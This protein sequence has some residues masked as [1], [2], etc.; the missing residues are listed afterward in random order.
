MTFE[1][2]TKRDLECASDNLNIE[3]SEDDLEYYDEVVADLLQEL[4]RIHQ[5]R[6]PWAAP[7]RGCDDTRSYRGFERTRS[8]PAD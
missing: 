3:L 4:G 1:P 7:K 5:L 8:A 6:E 2:P